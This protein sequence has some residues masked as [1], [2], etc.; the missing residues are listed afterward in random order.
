MDYERIKGKGA[1]SGGAPGK[2][3][4]DFQAV[5]TG[6]ATVSYAGHCIQITDVNEPPVVTYMTVSVEENAASPA[7]VGEIKVT[8][9]D[10]KDQRGPGGTPLSFAV[11]PDG[12]DAGNPCPFALVP[13]PCTDDA[14][15]TCAN[16]TLTKTLDFEQLAALYTS[17]FDVRLG[18]L[19]VL[20]TASDTGGNVVTGTFVV[21]VDDVN[22]PPS[23]V[24]PT[25]IN[26]P[27]NAGVGAALG[28]AMTI[29]DPDDIQPG[30]TVVVVE[31]MSVPSGLFT[32]SASG[33]KAQLR[34]NGPLDFENRTQYDVVLQVDDGG[35]GNKAQASMSSLVTVT[36][37][38]TDVADVTITSIAYK[39]PVVSGRH[40][41]YHS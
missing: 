26:V 18:A 3:C 22:E 14:L 34:L 35:N 28:V 24:V 25:A 5:D 33:M 2:L 29:T 1:M 37:T 40:L 6:A 27:E 13:V 4:L 32:V 21:L 23:I 38:V 36:V 20:F 9:P 15:Q 7:V 41:R 31:S 30:L 39:T 17:H 8:D 16:I 19:T 12:W 10:S 11:K